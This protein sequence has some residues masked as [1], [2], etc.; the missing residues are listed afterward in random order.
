MQAFR[1]AAA[2]SLSSLPSTKRLTLSAGLVVMLPSLAV[3]TT[4]GMAVPAVVMLLCAAARPASVKAA[5]A[6]AE[7]ERMVAECRTIY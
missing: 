5:V 4:L 2:Y 1:T 7:G 3:L 6:M